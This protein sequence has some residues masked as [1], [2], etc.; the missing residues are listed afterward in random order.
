VSAQQPACILRGNGEKVI[1]IWRGEASADAGTRLVSA[2]QP[3][4]ALRYIACAV[5][6]GT[7]VVILSGGYATHRVLGIDR[8]F[9]GCEGNVYSHDLNGDKAERARKWKK[10]LDCTEKRTD[11]AE[12]C[13]K[14]HA[15]TEF[16]PRCPDAPYAAALLTDAHFRH[17]SQCISCLT[18]S[19][20]IHARVSLPP[21]AA[22]GR[23]TTSAYTPSPSI[24]SP[25]RSSKGKT[26]WAG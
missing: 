13:T 26:S 8:K 16:R 15:V 25:T 20:R 11:P 19:R 3:D 24:T 7:R 1:A 9:R 21:L 22:V 17:V 18:P 2:G 10:Y 6:P 12:D 14:A 5:P 23:A 4:L